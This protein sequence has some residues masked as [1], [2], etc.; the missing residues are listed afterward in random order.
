MEYIFSGWFDLFSKTGGGHLE[1]N[2][3]QVQYDVLGSKMSKSAVPRP[4]KLAAAA[5]IFTTLTSAE[6]RFHF[7]FNSKYTYGSK[8]LN[9]TKRK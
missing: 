1:I 6:T 5:A 3:M 4:N 9:T 2:R 7:L 8:T